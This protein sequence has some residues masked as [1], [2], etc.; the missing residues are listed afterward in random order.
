MFPERTPFHG[1]MWVMQDLCRTVARCPRG[2]V[3]DQLDRGS[4][5]HD[6]NT[7]STLKRQYD[8]ITS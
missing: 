5:L 1:I 8:I 7:Q 3:F 4:F 2:A 6:F